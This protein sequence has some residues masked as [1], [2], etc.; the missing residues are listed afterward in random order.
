MTE[1]TLDWIEQFD[2]HCP[3]CRLSDW[4]VSCYPVE[5]E[6]ELIATP[7]YHARTSFFQSRSA[8]QT[9]YSPNIY[10]III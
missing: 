2:G 10:P 7:E 6:V 8:T 1:I 3:P 4:Y 9:E 5:H